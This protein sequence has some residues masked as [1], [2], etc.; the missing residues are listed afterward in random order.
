MMSFAYLDSFD[1]KVLVEIKC[2]LSFTIGGQRLLL[3]LSR[4]EKLVINQGHDVLLNDLF[5]YLIWDLRVTFLLRIQGVE[6]ENCQ[7]TKLVIW[8][9]AHPIFCQINFALKNKSKESNS[10]CTKYKLELKLYFAKKLLRKMLL[11]LT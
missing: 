3:M 8:E 5:I 6:F 1:K 7:N 10:F 2:V 9:I 4:S 11:Y